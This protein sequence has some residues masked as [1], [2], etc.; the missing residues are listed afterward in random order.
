LVKKRIRK[1]IEHYESNEWGWDDYPGVH[2]VRKS[3]ADQQKLKDYI[4]E[5]MDDNYLDE[6]DLK[7]KTLSYPTD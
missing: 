1:Y 3:K 7:M 4:E 5:K 6:E 2:I